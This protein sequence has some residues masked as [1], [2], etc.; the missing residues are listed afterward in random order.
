VSTG[1]KTKGR[2]GRAPRIN[3]GS[4]AARILRLQAQVKR[5]KA[6]L[7]AERRKW[8]E[9]CPKG[10]LV[11]YDEC[12]LAGCYITVIEPFPSP[13]FSTL[14][15]TTYPGMM[16]EWEIDK[17]EREVGWWWRVPYGWWLSIKN[18]VHTYIEAQHT[19]NQFEADAEQALWDA[20]IKAA[21][22]DGLRMN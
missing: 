22:R 21:R 12:D 15:K 6:A 3:K 9:K 2:K 11:R 19:M 20:N 5:L 16:H 17:I 8:D 7:R 13:I 10:H 18:Y 1:R 14:P 4:N